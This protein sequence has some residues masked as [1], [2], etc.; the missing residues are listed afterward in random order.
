MSLIL[1]PLAPIS[2]S[3]PTQPGHVMYCCFH[4]DEL[5]VDHLTVS[6]YLS[7]KE[8]LVMRECRT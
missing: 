3:K 4:A 2:P 8:Q 7:A 1:M 5:T 6:Q